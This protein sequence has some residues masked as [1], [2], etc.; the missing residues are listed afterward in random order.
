MG[1]R[2]GTWKGLT[3]PFHNTNHRDIS[4]RRWNKRYKINTEDKENNYGK[5]M[6]EILA[7]GRWKEP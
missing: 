4:H 5:R 2:D 3:S 7:N 1:W 6:A